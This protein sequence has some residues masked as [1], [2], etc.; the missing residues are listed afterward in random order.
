MLVKPHRSRPTAR[1]LS[2]VLWLVALGLVLHPAEAA[3]RPLGLR[4]SSA[5]EK[6][7]IDGVPKEWDGSWRELTKVLSGELV[8]P[9][10][11]GAEV[12]LAYDQR[13]L[14]LAAD[15]VDDQLVAGGDHVELLVGIPGGTLR[16][17]RLYPGVPGKS[18]AR[19][20]HRSGAPVRGASVVEAPTARGYS[21]EAKIPWRS[22]PGT[23]TIRI[24]LR[25]GVYVHDA[26]RSRRA[27]AIIGTASSRQYRSLPAISLEPEVG[28]ATGLMRERKLKNPPTCNLLGNVWGGPMK[29]R[30][31]IYGPYVI[32]MGWDYRDGE[33]YYYRD[34]G[35]VP[36][37]RNDKA[38]R[39]VDLTGDRRDD[40]VLRKWLSKGGQTVEVI[41]VLS[42]DGADDVPESVFAHE[43]RLTTQQGRIDNQVRMAPA[44]SRSRIT[45]LDGRAQGESASSLQRAFHTDADPL[46]LPW[47]SVASQTYAWRGGKFTKVHEKKQ[48]ARPAAPSRAVAPPPRRTGGGG[49]SAHDSVYAQFR[50]DRNVRGRPSFDLRANLAG[51]RTRERVVVHD[52]QLAAFGPGFRGGQAYAA[53]ELGAFADKQDIESVEAR[54]VT[55]DGR[56]ELLVEGVMRAEGP[57]EAGGREVQRRVLLIYQLREQGLTRIFA[58][59]LERRIGNQRVIGSIRFGRRTIELRPGRVV[60]FTE[61]TYPFAQDVGSAGGFEPLLL[62]WSGAKPVRYRFDGRTFRPQ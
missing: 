39:L 50:A 46:L 48:A 52:R 8:G 34:I 32:V 59:E 12:L 14:Y 13:H 20:T 57:P 15:V 5:P 30:V 45:I 56:A 10:D 28:F 51:D 19:A 6:I 25:G 58:A 2:G 61:R 26:D 36:R 21:L 43:L 62:P 42:F 60:G 47:G 31:L 18:R 41:E 44:G 54:D 7:R 38:C 22:I 4:A 53:V 33:Q 16:S 23:Q 27:D 29:E 24:G 49:G 11:C 35:Y 40:L 37:L 1:G 55:S 17:L 9:S 3:A